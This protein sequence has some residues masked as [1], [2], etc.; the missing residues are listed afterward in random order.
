MYLLK[1]LTSAVVNAVS[2][3][4][5]PVDHSGLVVYENI[6][7][8][9]DRN[10]YNPISSLFGKKGDTIIYVAQNSTTK[11]NISTTTKVSTK[12]TVAVNPVVTK[13]VNNTNVIER[14][15][16][17]NTVTSG[18]TSEDLETRLQELNNKIMSKFFSLSTGNG[19]NVTNIY[20]QIAQSQRI[21]QLTN[22]VINNPTINGGSINNTSISAG[23]ISANSASLGTTTLTNLTVSNTS[24]STYAGGIAV[25]SGCVSVNG[26][27]LGTG[28]GGY[29][30]VQDEGGALT[31]RTTINFV[32]GGVVA[33]DSGSVTTV[34][35][36]GTSF[37]GAPNSI[38]ATDASGALIAT[39]TQLTVGNLISTTTASSYFTGNLGVGTTSPYAPL[40]VVGQIVGSYFT[41]TTSATSTFAGGIQTN[42]LNV[43]STIAT[44]SFA[45]GINITG[46]C[47][48]VNGTCFSGTV[49]S[50]LTFTYPL[51]E[52]SNIVSLA[53]GTTTAN[54]WGTLQTFNFSKSYQRAT[55]DIS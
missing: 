8:W 26:V 20:Q 35:I 51:Q 16:E 44:S 46:G 42:L 40:S 9:V 4:I 29:S 15:I 41:A 19:G 5:N 7:S 17:K 30:I 47:F 36:N 33:S 13:V 31:A 52:S 48:A 12:N 6:N 43:T 28:N 2:K 53:F 39:G 50:P 45:N 37:T 3:T 1:K 10:I 21:D 27:C 54:T 32:G 14:I 24:T 22:T 11:N 34:T 55:I 38:V 25:S 18:I 49:A 23:S